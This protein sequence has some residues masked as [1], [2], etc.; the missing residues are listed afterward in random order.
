M[1]QNGIRWFLHISAHSRQHSDE[2]VESKFGGDL[3]IIMQPLFECLK[4]KIAY[5][6]VWSWLRMHLLI[7]DLKRNQDGKAITKFRRQ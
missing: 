4:T 3:R 5:V 2:K 6:W 1:P 7:N